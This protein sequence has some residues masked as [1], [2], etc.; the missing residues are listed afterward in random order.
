MNK[1]LL[2]RIDEIF[3]KKLELKTGWGKNEVLAVYREAVKEA[4]M[5]LLD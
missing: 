4:L 3:A 1:K 5:E 2:E